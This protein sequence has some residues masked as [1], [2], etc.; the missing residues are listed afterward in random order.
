MSPSGDKDEDENE[1]E[2]RDRRWLGELSPHTF[3]LVPLATRRS[4]FRVSVLDVHPIERW[5]RSNN[6]L[7]WTPEMLRPTMVSNPDALN[8]PITAG[9]ARI[10]LDP[11]NTTAEAVT[12]DCKM[13]V[14]AFGLI[15]PFFGA[16][17]MPWCHVVKDDGVS[18]L[19]QL[20]ATQISG[21]ERSLLMWDAGILLH[22]EAVRTDVSGS[23]YDLIKL[24]VTEEV[25]G[26]GDTAVAEH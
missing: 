8:L 7:I 20:F 5:N 13:A 18:D 11:V 2:D 15:L 9:V 14:V 25:V 1:D 4:E 12:G 26:E 21:A 6:Q 16:P 3:W 19:E 22:A 24:R 17:T 10:R 23:Y